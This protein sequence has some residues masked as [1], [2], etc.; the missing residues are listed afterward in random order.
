MGLPCPTSVTSLTENYH[1]VIV[2]GIIRVDYGYAPSSSRIPS[3]TGAD[4]WSS[5]HIGMAIVCACLPTLRPLVTRTG[6]FASAYASVRQRYYSSRGNRSQS[7]DD[8]LP[9]LSKNHGRLY[10]EN[11]SF[12]MTTI[13]VTSDIQ[14]EELSLSGNIISVTRSHV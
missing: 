12:E 6:V 13:T 7:E 14:V 2:T 5:I 10:E 8:T 9:S 3:Y 1:S 4:L 11:R